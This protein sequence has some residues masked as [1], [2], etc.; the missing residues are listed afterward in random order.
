MAPVRRRSLPPVLMTGMWLLGLLAATAIGFGAVHRVGTAATGAQGPVPAREV[1]SSAARLSADPTVRA[2][3]AGPAAAGRGGAGPG[4]TT[5]PA[6]P[7][8]GPDRPEA[9]A[10]ST[11]EPSGRHAD[12]PATGPAPVDRRFAVDGGMVAVRCTGTV[13]ALLYAVPADGFR[14]TVDAGGPETVEMEFAGSGRDGA[15]LRVSCVDGQPVARVESG[16]D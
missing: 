6:T 2:G 14:S 3:G 9:T 5:A 13:V 16:G 11:P 4:A 7:S 15:H 8:P 10:S 1:A 12:P